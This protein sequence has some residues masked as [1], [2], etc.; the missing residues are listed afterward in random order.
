M[1]INVMSDAIKRG[2]PTAFS[3][4]PAK[5]YKNGF[6][7]FMRD[8]KLYPNPAYSFTQCGDEMLWRNAQAMPGCIVSIKLANKNANGTFTDRGIRVEYGIAPG[9]KQFLPN[10]SV[11][12]EHAVRGD[13][14]LQAQFQ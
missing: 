14:F 2:D 5:G 8:F 7:D 4:L 9:S 13:G 1:K 11:Y 6:A 12:A 3:S 10:N